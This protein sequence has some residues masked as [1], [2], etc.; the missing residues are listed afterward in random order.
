[1]IPSVFNSFGNSLNQSTQ[2]ANQIHNKKY[3]KLLEEKISYKCT[4]GILFCN[5]FVHRKMADK[6]KEKK[7]G[8][9]QTEIN[10]KENA[11]NN[12]KPKLIKFEPEKTKIS[13]EENNVFIK[14][15]NYSFKG[16]K[17]LQNK[18]ISFDI[19][20]PQIKN[21]INLQKENIDDIQFYDP[22]KWNNVRVGKNNYFNIM[23]QN[24]NNDSSLT[25]FKN[26]SKLSVYLINY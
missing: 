2:N 9:K 19:I 16:Q 11:L 1:M 20:A 18:E 5:C 4:H 10:K 23:N 13:N 25:C 14:S 6:L 7:G 15:G 12:K 17:T 24:K 3:K 26:Y 21:Q 8:K 22:R